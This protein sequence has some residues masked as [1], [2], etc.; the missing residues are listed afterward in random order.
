MVFQL[1]EHMDG[2]CDPLEEVEAAV[3]REA[4]APPG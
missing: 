1:L 4:V 2:A 3:A